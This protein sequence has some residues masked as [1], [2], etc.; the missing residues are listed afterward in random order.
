LCDIATEV[1]EVTKVELL[2]AIRKEH[3]DEGEGIR[4]IAGKRRVHRRTVRAAID[5]AI[6]PPRQPTVR[7][8]PVL[9]AALRQVVDGWLTEDRKAPRK[10]RHTAKRVFDRL[11]REQGYTGAASAVRK[12]VSRRKREVGLSGEAHVPLTHE[13]GQE[14]EVDWYEAEVD[15]PWCLIPRS[16]VR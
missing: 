5:S 15:F 9:T 12:Y 11:C 6:P 8:P 7:E 2:E 14:G 1:D 4:R 10:Q 3:F 13:P 16:A